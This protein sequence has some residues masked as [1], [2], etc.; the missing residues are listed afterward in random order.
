[1]ISDEAR[2]DAGHQEGFLAER[3]EVVALARLDDRVE[4]LERVVGVDEDL[5][6]EVA[7]VA[8]ARDG[9]GGLGDLHVGD[10]EEAEVGTSGASLARMA[11]ERG[12]WTA[13]IAVVLGDVLDRHVELAD[14]ILEVAQVGLGGGHEVLVVGVAEHD[15]V[16]EHEAARHR[17]RPC[18]CAWPGLQ[19]RMSRV[20]TPAR[21]FSESLPRIQYLYSGEESK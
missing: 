5:V 16:L 11:R 1:M 13:S 7:G 10:A 21:N 3:E 15:A 14:Q 4:H 18:T 9:D 6:A 12:P 8:G 2:L 19:R 17:T 20:I